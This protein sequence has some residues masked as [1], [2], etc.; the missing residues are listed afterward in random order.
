MNRLT[1]EKEEAKSKYDDAVAR[2]TSEI[3]ETR[4]RHQ[5]EIERMN[6]VARGKEDAHEDKLVFMTKKIATFEEGQ[7]AKETGRLKEIDLTEQRHQAQIQE[8]AS[9]SR[10]SENNLKENIERLNNE[11][12]DLSRSLKNE[13]ETTQNKYE[14]E[15]SRQSVKHQTTLT[16]KQ[17]EINEVNIQVQKLIA[18]RVWLEKQAIKR[19]SQVKDT[20]NALLEEKQRCKTLGDEINRIKCMLKEKED[21]TELLKAQISAT[22]AEKNHLEKQVYIMQT[23]CDELE[24]E[25]AP[26]QKMMK[27]QKGDGVMWAAKLDRSQREKDAL[28]RMMELQEQKAKAKDAEMR[29][30]RL[31]ARNL[32]SKVKEFEA[33]FCVL[34]GIS[35]GK[36]LRKHVKTSYHRFVKQEVAR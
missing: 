14:T 35:D 24:R 7:A 8:L 23:K 19:E 16:E 34:A 13:L 31:T 33:E 27:Q 17:N 9:N 10:S 32:D 28:Q 22:N 21:D 1:K 30:L 4:C 11:L 3:A 36:I 12:V 6:A 5:A 20:E 15:M 18:K 26:L 29:T 2:Y 25:R